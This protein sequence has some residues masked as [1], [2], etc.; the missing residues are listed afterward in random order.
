VQTSSF[1]LLL[2]FSNKFETLRSPL[3]LMFPAPKKVICITTRAVLRSALQ[4]PKFKKAKQELSHIVTTVG[5]K[6]KV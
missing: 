3:L 5:E 2:N 6:A 1:V 4:P